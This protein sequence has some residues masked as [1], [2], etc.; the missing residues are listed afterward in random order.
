MNIIGSVSTI[1]SR[2]DKILPTIK[3]VLDQ[4]V[5][6]SHVEINVPVHCERLGTQ[7]VIPK[8]FY[9]EPRLRIYRTADYGPITKVAPTFFRHMHEDVFIFSFDDD[10]IYAPNHLKLMLSDIDNYD[11]KIIARHG[12]LFK[13]KD[14]QS[15]FGTMKVD[16]VEGYGGIL[17]P[18]KVVDSMFADYLFKALK[19]KPCI[20]ADDIVLSHY[21]RAKRIPLWICNNKD[22]EGFNPKGTDY[23]KI[24]ALIDLGKG[25][26]ANY[27][28][29]REILN[30]LIIE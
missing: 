11:D 18:M 4:D 17:Y 2:I 13:D 21:F 8:E 5:T 24:N 6:I 10:I 7:Y 1:P 14:I 25:H 27:T 22:P 19:F 28:V 9:N 3:S 20:V 26:N 29:V 23:N 12:G 16:Y 15:Y 30:N